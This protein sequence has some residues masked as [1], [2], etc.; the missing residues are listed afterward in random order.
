MNRF[1][2][3]TDRAESR[4]LFATFSISFLLLF[5]QNLPTYA[6]DLQLNGIAIHSELRKDFYIAALYTSVPKNNAEELLTTEQDRR[7]VLRVLA[8]RW[9]ARSF[10]QH[11]TQ[12]ILINNESDELSRLADTIL[13]FTG[14]L[15]GKLVS[16]DEI[17]ID[18]PLGANLTFSINGVELLAVSDPVQGRAFFDLL[19]NAWIGAR[20]PSSNF[21]R[22]ILQAPA[23]AGD[24]L[25]IFD[26]L[27]PADD[28]VAAIQGWSA[29]AEAEPEPEPEPVAT[30]TAQP[31]GPTPEQVAAAR[32]K[33]AEEAAAAAAAEEA[34]RLAEQA[35]LAKE[36]EEL[37]AGLTLLYR[38]NVM[39]LIYA[40]VVY[41][42]RAIDRNQEGVV[43]IVVR[44]K[45]DGELI[46]A[47]FAEESEY[48]LLNRAALKAVKD[49]APFPAAPEKLA[50]EELVLEIP[51]RFQI[52][53]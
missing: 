29:E 51:I 3:N 11:W 34:A 33:A 44:L 30:P 13:D 1:A 2:I 20:P 23:D 45:K 36:V 5:F 4:S 39:K 6:Q 50:E 14:A 27:T 7:M 10:D 41:P 48:S 42:G 37:A 25:A 40:R 22:D 38:S 9:S 28:R 19:L 17:I 24:L 53:S 21:K 35:R 43:Q 12:S 18:S 49:A 15:G 8:S 26:G 52:P 32:A 31:R 16:G 46:E 47:S